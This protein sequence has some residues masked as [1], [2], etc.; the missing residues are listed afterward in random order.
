MMMLLKKSQLSACT[1]STDFSTLG[2]RQHQQSSRYAHR[3]AQ[4][5]S[6]QQSFAG[7]LHIEQGPSY[8]QPHQQKGWRSSLT[9]ILP[10]LCQAG[11]VDDIGS[12]GGICVSQRNAAGQPRPRAPALLLR[13]LDNLLDVAADVA[14][15]RPPPAEFILPFP[16][17]HC[18]GAAAV[19]RGRTGRAGR[20][21]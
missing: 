11:N 15:V 14:S 5:G 19:P 2:S 16:H 10:E 1:Q 8:P 18:R 7:L 3:A 9:C 6:K 12:Q 21:G 17:R 13:G 4:H 20:P